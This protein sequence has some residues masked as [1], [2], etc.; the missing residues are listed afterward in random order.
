MTN[1]L[2]IDNIQGSFVTGVGTL[3]YNN[4]STVLGIDGK[5]VGSGST[6]ASFEVDSTNDGLHFKVN[7]RSHGLHAFNN[8]VRITDVESDV[9]ETK[10]SADFDLNSTSDISVVSSSNFATFEGVGVGTTN[11]GYA[12]IGDEIISYTGVADGSITG[13]TTRGI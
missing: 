11:Y 10:L 1:S 4:G 5:T 2:L 3:G 6:I 12:R 8:L 13:I 9:P 7:H